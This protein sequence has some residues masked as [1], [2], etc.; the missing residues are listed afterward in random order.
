MT[1]KCLYFK[2]E[3][4]KVLLKSY[5]T[6]YD[7]FYIGLIVQMIRTYNG[8]STLEVSPGTGLKGWINIQKCDI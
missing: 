8:V 5:K 1:K 7:T 3:Y 4:Y 2:L 6:L